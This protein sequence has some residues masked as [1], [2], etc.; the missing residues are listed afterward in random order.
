MTLRLE[1]YGFELE[2]GITKIDD[3]RL[4]EEIVEP[5][6]SDLIDS[7]EETGEIIDPIIVDEKFG[8]VLDGM[9]RVVAL[10]RLGH[11]KI[12]A[13]FVN[14][15]SS[16]V[17]LGSWCRVWND[18]S[19][20]RAVEICEGLRFELERCELENAISSL[21]HRDKKLFLASKNDCFKISEIDGK[22]NEVFVL[23]EDIERAIRNEGFEPSFVS[24]KNILE[25]LN[26]GEI[27]ILIPPA[28][29]EEVIEISQSNKVFP[30]KM[31]RHVIPAR[32]LNVKIPLPLLEE[33]VLKADEK[34]TEKL[35]NSQ[36]ER[37]PPGSSF[38]GRN[39][40]EELIVFR[41]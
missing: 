26:P 38:G 3:I 21:I 23:A 31:T 27:S 41:N 24:E 8:V 36:T 14:Y 30:P 12:P 18:I 16:K 9:H 19:I 37:L 32:P 35:K 17:K 20:E 11:D 34:M 15:K 4:H 10:S 40:E 5:H 22:I 6:L 33:S 28:K 29:K 2:I 1:V 13:C 25:K 7:M 39:Y